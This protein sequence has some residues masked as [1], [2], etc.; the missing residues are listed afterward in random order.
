MLD[1]HDHHYVNPL[2]A[3]YAIA[4]LVP[5]LPPCSEPYLAAAEALGWAYMYSTAWGD[6]VVDHLNNME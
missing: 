4:A 1:T 2:H 5:H 6:L 3:A